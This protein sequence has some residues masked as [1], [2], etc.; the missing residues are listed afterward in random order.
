MAETRKMEGEV[1]SCKGMIPE[2]DQ[3]PSVSWSHTDE[4]SEYE[5]LKKLKDHASREEKEELSI[6]SLN[7]WKWEE[8]RAF[9][10]GK[11]L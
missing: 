10:P 2:M 7:I 8:E 11:I 6:C 5:A 1:R 9:S 3:L 4:R